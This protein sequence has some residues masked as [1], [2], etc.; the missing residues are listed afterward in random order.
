MA[1]ETIGMSSVQ[2]EGVRDRTRTTMAN[3]GR[4][5]EQRPTDI[6]QLLR[7]VDPLR[8][9]VASKLAMIDEFRAQVPETERHA[10]DYLLYTDLDVLLA[11]YLAA[12]M[13][14]AFELKGMERPSQLPV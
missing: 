7:H 1:S 6:P 10:F 2:A 3:W 8:G 14:R 5:L 4:S 11:A 12:V 9:L 13:D